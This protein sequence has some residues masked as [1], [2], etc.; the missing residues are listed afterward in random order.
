[1]RIKFQSACT[2]LLLILSLSVAAETLQVTTDRYDGFYHRGETVTFRVIGGSGV[3]DYVVSKDSVGT[4]SSGT[5]SLGDKPSEIRASLDEPGVIHCD[6]TPRGDATSKPSKVTGGAAIDPHLIKPSLPVPDDFD[7]YWASQKK[8]LA[9]E[10]MKPV[11]TKVDSPDEAVETFDVQVNCP[12][13]APVSAYLAVPKDAK[14]K[15]LPAILY[16]HSAGV[17]SS[18][19]KNAVHGADLGLIALDFNAHGVP[20]GKPPQYYADLFSG[21]L[22]DYPSRGITEGRDQVYFRGMF[23]R[24]MR[25]ADYLTTRPEWDG[26]ILIVEGPSQG[27]GQA[28]VAAGLDPRITLCLAAVP[29]LCDHT[30]FKANRANGWPRIVPKD[31]DGKFDEKAAETARYFDAM[32][33]ATR[34]KCNTFVTV[35]LID[36]TCAATSVFA[37]YNAIPGENKNI[38]PV[39]NMGHAFPKDLQEEF[40]ARIVE[41]VQ[42]RTGQVGPNRKVRQARSKGAK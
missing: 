10:P 25:A 13:G 34:I 16:P 2:G 26:K 20:N 30:G 11:L 9:A 6:V 37:A 17:Q 36:K 14:P 31:A 41:H 15:S 40:D 35:G 5:L 33:F 12:G 23:L 24:L 3:A 22:K 8:L 21:P 28:L 19:L 42:I 1:M 32:N 27:G 4:L 38:Y 39:P 29:A 7:A 18:S